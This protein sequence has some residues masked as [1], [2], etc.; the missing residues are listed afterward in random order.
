[1]RYLENNIFGKYESLGK[2][3]TF[4]KGEL[5]ETLGIFDQGIWK[6]SYICMIQHTIFYGKHA[7]SQFVPKDKL[8]LKYI[9]IIDTR[10]LAKMVTS[11]FLTQ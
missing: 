4:L 10:N 2:D 7:R 8:Q 3:E 1:M 9:H 5:F 6:I 11:I